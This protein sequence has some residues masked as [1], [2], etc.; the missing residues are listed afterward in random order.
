MNNQNKFIKFMKKTSPFL[1][2]IFVYILIIISCSFTVSTIRAKVTK[3]NLKKIVHLLADKYIQLKYGDP[4]REDDPR[5]IAMQNQFDV[6]KCKLDLSYDFNDEKLYGTVYITSQDLSDTLNQIYLNL[7]SNLKVNYVKIDNIEA[8]FYQGANFSSPRDSKIEQ[9]YYKNYLVINSK[10]KLTNKQDF[11]IEINYEGKPKDNGF[12]SFSSKKIDDNEVVYTL[13]EP[14]FAPAWWPCKDIL[15]DKFLA[16]TRITVPPD[17]MAASSGILKDVTTSEKGDKIFDWVS[18]YPISSY[19]VSFT[20]AKYDRWDTVY[21]ALDTSKKM[22]LE[23]FSYPKYT[24]AAKK[25]WIKTPEMIHTF[26]TLFGEYPFINE[27]YGMAMFGWRG[28]AMEHQTLTSMGYTLVTGNGS[29]E[30]IVAHELVHQWF[31]DAVSPESW[32][33]IWLNE[34]FASY[35]E[36]LWDEHLK[37]K[38]ILKTEMSY[39]DFGLFR[40]TVYNPSGFIFSSVVYQ[41][42]AWCLHMLRGVTGDSVFFKILS[43]YYDKYKYKNANTSQ[44]K[45]VCE[46]VSG[47]DL[48]A[49]FDEWIFKGTGRPSYEYSY[50]VD[51]FMGDK[52]SEV[53]TLRINVEQKQSDYDVYKMPIRITVVTD[54]GEQELK[55][56]NLKKRQQFEQPVRGNIKNVLFDRDNWI[57]KEVKKV[58]YKEF[59]DN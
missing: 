52:N 4:E 1:I 56:Y 31:G 23:Y 11:T 46:E 7:Y 8:E 53:H 22:P 16:E 10:G 14:S 24:K 12:D 28:G 19:L 17:Y 32:K 49:F 20:V 55:F 47:L 27:K 2:I 57:L 25:D 21:V 43:T 41:K 15:T 59:Y 54:D 40:G 3:Q 29:N 30:S 6:Q 36:V 13:S 42:G 51:D 35:G 5:I 37:G 39:K 44:F 38:Q 9:S 26:A 34:G 45:A 33:D 48:S 18:N 58:D 50:K